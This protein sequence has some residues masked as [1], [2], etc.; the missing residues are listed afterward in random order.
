MRVKGMLCALV[1]A[2][3]TV[4]LLVP[5]TAHAQQPAK[6]EAA[7]E[8]KAAKGRGA[9]PDENIKSEQAPNP[10]NTAVAAP[11]S[12]GG[13]KSRGGT[14]T[15]HVDNHTSYYIAAY[16]DGGFCGTVGPWGDIWCNVGSG[17]TNMY[18]RAG[19]TD[20]STL[21]WGPNVGYVDGEYT[22]RLWP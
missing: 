13:E 1:V 2:G 11:A 19:F 16:M 15:V 17:N 8:T 7:V 4:T 20:G 3:C 6:R 5:A 22:W 21:T 9:G 10:V 18:A 12:K 14:S